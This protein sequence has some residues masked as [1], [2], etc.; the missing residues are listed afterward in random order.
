MVVR[1]LTIGGC[2]NPSVVWINPCAGL[3]YQQLGRCLSRQLNPRL[4]GKGADET[5]DWAATW[6]SR[7]LQGFNPIGSFDP[8]R[9]S[10]R[11]GCGE[12]GATM[13]ERLHNGSEM[14]TRRR[15]KHTAAWNQRRCR[16]AELGA[17]LATLCRD[18]SDPF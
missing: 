11:E 8:C 1:L 4:G 10:F 18:N 5:L 13:G 12:Q 7:V 9:R 6:K 16:L 2:Y 3:Q 14:Q 17:A 15:L